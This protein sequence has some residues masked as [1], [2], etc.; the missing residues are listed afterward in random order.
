MENEKELQHHVIIVKKGVHLLDPFRNFEPVDTEIPVKVKK[1]TYWNRRI[2][3]GDVKIFKEI[4]KVN[5]KDN[6]SIKK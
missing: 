6:Q 1:S 2:K 5:K 3:Q 4:K